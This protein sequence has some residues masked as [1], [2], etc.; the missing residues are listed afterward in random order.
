M[1][2]CENLFSQADY[3]SGA[4]ENLFSQAHLMWFACKNRIYPKKKLQ[5]LSSAPTPPYH[6]FLSSQLSLSLHHQLLISPIPSPPLPSP[7]SLPPPAVERAAVAPRPP[8]PDPAGGRPGEG[9]GGETMFFCFFIGFSQAGH[10]PA[11]KNG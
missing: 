11:C 3:L 4:C 10:C 9:G 7:P 1:S 6:S 5:S 8:L 2:T